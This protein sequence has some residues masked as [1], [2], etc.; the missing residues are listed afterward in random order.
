MGI[1]S[2]ILKSI[3]RARN[4]VKIKRIACAIEVVEMVIHINMAGRPEVFFMKAIESRRG[5][6]GGPSVVTTTL[7][8]STTEMLADREGRGM[9]IQT[10]WT[11]KFEV[12]VEICAD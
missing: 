9:L 4:Q 1:F 7:I 12:D 11:G 10:L 3:T 6:G 2:H 5:G 8:G